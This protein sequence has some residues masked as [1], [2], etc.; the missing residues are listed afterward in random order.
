MGKVLALPKLSALRRSF[1]RQG[2]KVVFTNGTFDIIHRGHVEYLQAAKKLGDVLIIGLNTDTSIRRIKGK[3]RPINKNADRAAVLS[4]LG[5]VDYVCLFGDDTP[6]RLIETLVPDVLVKGADWKL[7][8]IVGSD[9]VAKTGGVVKT[10]RLTH[11][12][13]TT[14]TIERVLKA[15][16]F[17]SSVRRRNV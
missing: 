8:E 17:K 13:S 9:V 3:G 7:G 6:Y 4:A 11:G 12:R 16:C 1:R 2:K 15:Y 5:C 14:N 10:I